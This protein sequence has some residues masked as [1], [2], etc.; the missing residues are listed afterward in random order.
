M[1]VQYGMTGA[2]MIAVIKKVN[3]IE[4]GEL[5]KVPLFP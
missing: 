5:S 4:N 1:T 2:R 3:A